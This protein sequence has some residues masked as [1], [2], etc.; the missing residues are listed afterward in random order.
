M[1][2]VTRLLMQGAAGAGGDTT[3]V[4]DVFSTYL[5]KG[6]GATQAISN[7]I[8]LSNNNA[9]NGVTFDA[10]GDYLTTSS[11]SD[12][13][14]GTG[15]YTVEC[16]VRI[17]SGSNNYG[18]FQ[19]GGLNTSYLTGPTLFYYVG[20][21][22]TFGNG[23]E[24]GSNTHPTLN[25]W[26]HVALVKNGSST[27]LYY[28]GT[29]VKTVSDTHNYTNQSFALGG[30]YSTSYLG[31]VSISNFRVVKGT[32]VYTSSFT[33]PTEPLTNV[34]NTKLLCCNQGSSVTAATV[35]AGTITVNGNPNISSGP[36]TATDAK[37]G[38]VWAK[39]RTNTYGHKLTDT[40]R[41]N[42]KVLSSENANAEDTSSNTITS[43][44]ATGFS[45]DS[46]AG[47]NASNNDYGSWTFA[48]QKGFFDIVTWTGDATNRLL[49][50]SLGCIPG[51]IILKKTSATDNWVVYHR[52]N[53]DTPQNVALF[54]NT[55]NST[56][57]GSA[58]WNNTAPTSTHFTVSNWQNESGQTYVAYV[59]AGGDA[60]NIDITS[61]T[62]TNLG[63]SF[64]GSYPITNINDGTA[65]T[66]NAQSIGTV[67]GQ[68]DIYVDLTSPH[69]VTQY[70]IAPQGGGTTLYNLPIK[71]EVY[72]TNDT[73]SWNLL[74]TTQ[75]THTGWYAGSYRDFPIPG[76][77]SYRY[78]RIKVLRSLD[79]NGAATTATSISEWKLD[80]FSSSAT[81]EY[82]FGEGGDQNII[83]TGSFVGNGNSD[84]PEV[85][86]GWEP[87]F[88]ITKNASRSDHWYMF[89][90]MRGM[91]SGA[92]DQFLYPYLNSA[93]TDWEQLELTPTGFKIKSNNADI[94]G[95]GETTIYLAIRRP[96]GLVGKPVEDATK[97]FAMDMGNG[98]S[99]IPAYDSG[100]PVDFMF[101]KQINSNANW[102]ASSRLSGDKFLY[103]NSSSVEVNGG[104]DYVF[105]SNVGAVV[106][107]WT[108]GHQGW[109]WKRGAGFDVVT[110]TGTGD[111]SNSG[112]NSTSQTLSHSL[113]KIPEM[114]WVKGRSTGY[115]WFVYHSGQN[116]GTNPWNYYL[117]LNHTDAEQESVA[118]YTNA[119]WNNTAPTSTQFSL[120]PGNDI[121]A[122]NDTYIALLFAS[123]DGISK[124]G[125]YTGTGST[126]TITTG[127]SPKFL[128]IKRT[129]AANDWYVLDTLRGWTSGVD[130]AIKLNV[131][132]SQFNSHD[133]GDPTSTG[134]TV[135]STNEGWN[136]NGGKYIYYAHA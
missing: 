100:F 103:P 44:N 72:G 122:N 56:S 101:E 61:K 84:G 88:I 97:V 74:T 23:A 48:K 69:V 62:L 80:G 58:Y 19:G 45:L 75:T 63:D 64:L 89:D 99:T 119:V 65:E 111:N 21:G 53:T 14:M 24:Q 1:D 9:G 115:N 28:N 36:F 42:T 38:L 54:L 93:E 124:V 11:S 108:N 125:R 8:K 68:F 81:P 96:D 83:K 128:I 116:G 92:N 120:G 70:K 130:Q 136:T 132:H 82:K 107:S 43:F 33:V 55:N 7:G 129:D 131:N 76:V 59:F 34:T 20:S 35:S 87:Q 77:N 15:D 3:Y 113:G 106:G 133:L 27:T 95:S 126:L 37:G 47:V 16:W 123:V 135:A 5:Y 79:S 73:S 134:F 118:P 13:S 29:D 50:H 17:N 94:N 90:S 105:D 4:D 2:N 86:L 6:N 104:G 57:T 98:S 18:I 67:T 49:S 85:H 78:W 10:N 121:N 114:I 39:S 110:Y 12:Y 60:T 51:C 25:Q 117:R 109:M 127:F 26:F 52:S 41:G 31:P 22:L 112:P 32:A 71:F 46:N 91:F 102:Y 30:Y 66:S 40:V